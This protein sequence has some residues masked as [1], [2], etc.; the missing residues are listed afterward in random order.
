[1]SQTGAKPQREVDLPPELQEDSRPAEDRLAARERVV[2]RLRLLWEARGFVLKAAIIGLL[3]ATLNAFMIP[4][5]YESTTRLM[6][7]DSR[8]V[9]SLSLMAGL[10][11]QATG[12]GGFAGDLLGMKSTGALFVGVLRSRTV[13]DRIVNRFGL[14]RVYGTKL[15]KDARERLLRK[16]Q[17]EE[18]RKS[19]IITLTVTDRDPK[20]AAAIAGAY[21]E[22]LDTLMAQ[23]STSSARRERIFLEQRLNTVKEDLESAEKDLS[24]FANKNGTIEISE[25]TKAMY[26]FAATLEGRLIAAQSE[27]E[28]LKQIYTESNVRVRSA[29]ARV[30]E[31]RSQLQKF[32]GKSADAGPNTS[33]TA[34]DNLGPTLRALP[35]LGVPYADKFRHLKVEEVVFETLTRQYELAK[36]QE[37]KEIPTVKVL[38]AADVPEHKSFPPRLL[39][40]KIGTALGIVFA[41]LWTLGSASWREIDERDPRK[42]FA[43]EVFGTFTSRLGRLSPN[44]SRS[45]GAAKDLPKHTD[46]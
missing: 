32:I 26:G 34:S 25:Q 17:I 2:T 33:E 6:P 1:M 31:L 21:V 28:G 15:Q 9:N 7:P 20:R 35:L 39:I 40:M 13:L 23:L 46:D 10:P 42:A 30:T 24:Q 19:G 12:L 3:L 22:E 29:Q 4:W 11:S 37:A 43:R 16:T 14:S 18:D 45:S 44:G 27:L 41:V 38:D 5:Q 36:V 8:S